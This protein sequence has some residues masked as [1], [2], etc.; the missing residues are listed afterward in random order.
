M[1]ARDRIELPTHG[2]SV[3]VA[4]VSAPLTPRWHKYLRVLRRVTLRRL[5]AAGVPSVCQP[6][7][8]HA[9]A[10]DRPTTPPRS[11][12]LP[13]GDPAGESWSHM[14]QVQILGAL[15]AFLAEPSTPEDAGAGA[16]SP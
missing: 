7:A 15:P 14:P 6:P 3:R 1:M 11:H 16:R 9:G 10:I 13:R 5:A 2:F 12:K 8:P 4:H